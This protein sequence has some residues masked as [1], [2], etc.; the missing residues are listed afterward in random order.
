MKKQDKTHTTKDIRP[1]K[2]LVYPLAP[3]NPYQNLLYS[4]LSDNH[5]VQIKFLKMPTTLQGFLFQ[6][7]IGL[8]ELVSDRI[9]GYRIL[10]I[11]WL[12]QLSFPGKAIWPWLSHA[13]TTLLVRVFL[14]VADLLGY[15][16]IWTV[17]DVVPHFKMTFNDV[18]MSQLLINRSDTLLMLSSA[19]LDKIDEYGL[20]YDPTKAII[21]PHGN[22]IDSYPNNISKSMARQKLGINEDSFAYLFFGTVLP[23]K[24][25]SGM[26]EA[27]KSIVKEHSEAIIIIAGNPGTPE[28]R[29]ELKDAKTQL[30]D[31]LIL[32]A[33]FVPDQEVQTYFNAS[34]VV[35]FPYLRI[36]N[37]G[38]ALLAASFGKPIVAPLLGAFKDLPA[39]SGV[40]YKA[41]DQ[42]ELEAAMKQ[43]ITKGSTLGSM[44]H[45]ALQYAQSLSWNT[46]AS[47]T[48]DVYRQQRL[49]STPEK[50]D[51]TSH[52]L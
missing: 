5:P 10:H 47:M 15:R 38:V 44:S 35:V 24:N 1:I 3:Q 46:I 4:S 45:A 11:H 43:T 13:V 40:F 41:G 37:S 52:R 30:G 50:H 8:Y 42:A 18:A 26:L 31:R 21:I 14:A 28:I 49:D 27:F 33:D 48:Y 23:Y 34:D 32:H 12:Y 16:I 17:H 9:R 25:A 20:N 51:G 6:I 2:I 29:K 36:T 19:T 39:K 22:Y 7:C